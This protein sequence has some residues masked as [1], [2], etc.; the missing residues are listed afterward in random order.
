ME[1]D[2][3]AAMLAAG[4]L[5]IGLVSACERETGQDTNAEKEVSANE[6]L[7]REHGVLRR[8]LI[9]YRETAPKIAAGT[10]GLDIPALAAAAALFR[11][12]GEAYHER[13]LEERYIF[14]ELGN[15]ANAALVATLLAQH[16]RGREI[17][18]FILDATKDGGIATARAK[19]LGSAMTSFARMYE[20]HTAREDTVLFPAFKAALPERRLEELSETFEEIERRQFGGDGFDQAVDRIAEIEQRLGVADLGTFTAPEPA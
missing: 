8:I 19:P 5:G 16:Q 13:E 18:A 17:T 15:G 7:M 6:D 12:F 1:L 9:L 14:P 11:D 20:A 4:V 10:A 3:R 2:R